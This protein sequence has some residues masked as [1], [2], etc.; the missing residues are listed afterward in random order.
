MKHTFPLLL[1]F[2]SLMPSKAVLSQQKTF[3]DKNFSSEPNGLLELKRT[4][5]GTK[6]EIYENLP[7]LEKGTL[8]LSWVQTMTSHEVGASQPNTETLYTARFVSQN[9]QLFFHVSFLGE[10]AGGKGAITVSGHPQAIGKWSVGETI[11]LAC[12]L[13]L[14]ENKA[15]MFVNDKEVAKDIPV[16]RKGPVQGL[17]LRDGGGLGL[18][19]GQF[20]LTIDDVL[21]THTAEK[22]ALQEKHRREPKQAN[23]PLPLNPRP[24]QAKTYTVPGTVITSWVG[25][26]LSGISG[27]GEKSGHQN[28]FGDWV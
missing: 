19:D 28:G 15:K 5:D 8:R 17:Q 11:K 3:A 26:S 18:Q 25:N 23:T 22:V 6:P 2:A 4:P 24:A 9:G 7:G 20:A 21:L 14:D 1:A 10:K 27:S 12:E 13:N 16:S